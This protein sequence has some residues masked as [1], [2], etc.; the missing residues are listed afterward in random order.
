MYFLSLF[1][2]ASSYIM[3]SIKVFGY[4]L[5]QFYPFGLTAG[6]SSLPGNDDGSTSSIL[7]SVP[8]PF[9]GPSYRFI[10]VNNNGD[11]TFDTELT[12][13]TA[14]A[15]PINGSHKMIAA[16]WTDIDTDPGG[17]LWYRTSTDSSI[18]QLGTNIIRTTFPSFVTFSATWMM[19]VTWEE[20][21]AYGCSN[22]SIITC[23]QRNTFQLV[24]ITNGVYSF[25]VF[26]YNK[27]TWAKSTQVGINAGDGIN[28]YSVP[29]SMK[30]S[31][32]N[33]TQMS[34]VGVPGQFVFRVDVRVN[35]EFNYCYS[36]PC[37]YGSCSELING[38]VCNCTPGY[39]G[40]RCDTNIDEC[41][42]DPCHNNGTCT[43]LVNNYQC[44]CA[45]G[46]NGTNCENNIDECAAQPC[47]N[48]GNCVDLINNYQCHCTDGFNGTHCL[49][50]IDD[51]VPDPC[52]NNGTCTDLVND[53][54]CYC[55]A[56]FNGTNCDFNI[57]E[58][59]S[60]PCQNNGTC[61]D[62]I[63]DY[64]CRCKDGFNGTTCL[65]NIDDCIPVPCQ[66]NGTCTDLVNDYNCD[67]VLGFYGIDCEN[68]IDDCES[69]PCQNN[70]TCTDMINDYLCHCTV[71]FNG[72]NCSN[73]VRSL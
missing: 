1:V 10:F 16:F 61:E 62:L 42:P 64:Q 8:F 12:Q 51:C 29:G 58:C 65:N 60:Q 37:V 34:N 50:N 48:H 22:T 43:D 30:D 40:S 21:A 56:G 7:I 54:Q 11:V 49:N 23:Q 2:V 45:A 32:L 67:C 69:Q 35:P 25:V 66:N 47:Q 39:T 71:G 68:N 28:Y 53:Y 27:I 55:V 70:G 5:S 24:L 14:Q 13:Y 26:N 41:L 46:F 31:M 73:K 59:A 63:N 15:F 36:S 52:Q 3:L 9:F 44:N 20:V 72:R 38:Y 6:D 19:V 4:P 57:D 17:S 18:L 33:L